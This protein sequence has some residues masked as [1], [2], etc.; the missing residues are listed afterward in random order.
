MIPVGQAYRPKGKVDARAILSATIL[1]A[2]TAVFAALVVWLWELSPI[3][4]LL[5]LT[6]LS[7]GMVIACVLAFMIDRLRLRHPILLGAVGLLCGLASAELVHYG[8]YL[9]FLDQYGEQYAAAV[10]AADDLSPERKQELLGRIS[11][12]SSE[13]ADEFLVAKTGHAG[14]FGSMLY[15]SQLGVRI[16]RVG[17]RVGREKGT[18]KRVWSLWGAE[19][20]LIAGVA[21]V[22]AW[23]R[24]SIPFCE[25]CGEWCPSTDRFVLLEGM[26]APAF[27]KAVRM[28]DLEAA[29]QLLAGSTDAK[30]IQMHWTQ[31]RLHCC[32]RCDQTFVDIE[33][34]RANKK[35]TETKRKRHLKR[36]RASPEMAALLREPALA[37][38]SAPHE[39]Q[40]SR[41]LADTSAT[42][43][44]GDY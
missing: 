16:Q 34:Y 27:A 24:A 4:T 25:D 10:E 23:V 31:S 14:F 17:E 5:I 39:P 9:H 8:H 6:P 43:I 11:N 7:Q 20:I 36:I 1:G 38:A 28:D 3:P 29:N 13:V 32:G 21:L 41:P 42:L 19:A 37:K 26:S 2:T 35:K 15:R 22:G 30:A 18:G 33:S 12:G 40:D 44:A